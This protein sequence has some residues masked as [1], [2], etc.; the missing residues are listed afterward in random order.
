MALLALERATA[1][2]QTADVVA[3]AASCQALA[4][5]FGTGAPSGRLDGVWAALR[6]FPR[7]P[8]EASVLAARLGG[9]GPTAA[10]LAGLG[11]ELAGAEATQWRA[12]LAG[13]R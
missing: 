9:D 8:A 2:S 11:L 6:R 12:A 13:L 3:P 7:E 5:R 1:V 10:A 4:V